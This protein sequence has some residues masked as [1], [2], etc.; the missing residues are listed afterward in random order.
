MIAFV[1][2]PQK[3]TMLPIVKLLAKAVV[4]INRYLM[5]K[6]SFCFGGRIAALG[7]SN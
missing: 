1:E 4:A 3:I 7:L 5:L 6:F 2:E